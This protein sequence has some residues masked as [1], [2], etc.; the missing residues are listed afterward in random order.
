MEP[1]TL[2]PKLPY[3]N[4]EMTAQIEIE[5][6]RMGDAGIDHGAWRY[7]PASSALISGVRAEKPGVMTLLDND[8]SD[9]R[10]VTA[11]ANSVT[12]EANCLNFF[13]QNLK[14]SFVVLL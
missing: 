3:L 12:G 10:I 4:A 9:L 7:V 14:S 5:L 11:A 6:F 13:S 8:E 2:R 1:W